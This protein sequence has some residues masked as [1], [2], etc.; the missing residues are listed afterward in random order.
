MVMNP[1]VQKKAH[2]AVDAV[3]GA[4]GLPDFNDEKIPYI[5]AV[6]KEVL[7]SFLL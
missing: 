1:E 6:L 3:I 4:D 5:E 7:R 2:A